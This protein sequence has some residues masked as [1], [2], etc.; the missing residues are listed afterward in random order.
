VRVVG[1]TDNQPIRS[2]RFPSNWHLSRERARVVMAM[3]QEGSRQPDRFSAEGRA[4][5]QPLGPNVSA[6][7]R[8]LNRRIE[9]V[10]SVPNAADAQ[11]VAGAAAAPPGQ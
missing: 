5:A 11:G 6:E 8:A 2:A 4:D 1:H 10:L 7:Q 3:L 9:I